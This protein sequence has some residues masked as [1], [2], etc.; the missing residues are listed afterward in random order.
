[1]SSKS[2]F[3]FTL[4]E[5]L[6]VI[7]IIGILIALLLPA[8]Q[9]AREAARRMQCAN[10][11][12]QVGLA[13]HG[14]HAAQLTFPPGSILW[15][16]S[17]D[18]GCR[19]DTATPTTYTGWGWGTFILPY[20]EQQAVYEGID[21]QGSS[22]YTQVNF[23]L[24][25]TR[26]NAFLCPSDPQ[27]GELIRFTGFGTNGSHPNDDCRQTN[28]VGVT[29]SQDWTCDGVW[30]KHLDHADG[31]MA[32]QR[33]CRIADIRDGTS[34]TLVVAEVT[35]AGAG[36]RLGFAWVTLALTD[37]LDGIN[38]PCTVPGGEFDCGLDNIRHTGPASYHPGGCHFTMADGSVQF[39]SESIAS[40]VIEGL[41]TRDVGEVISGDAL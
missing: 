18:A 35:G 19:P 38:G 30:P 14:Y 32:Q 3:G 31:V 37:T 39:L 22:I 9:A 1:M 25:A 10:N 20:L 27:G 11:F 40:T 15:R 2:Q 36:S 21:F 41:T 6:V 8:V 7:T 26:V 5:L 16:S 24:T 33:G 28:I 34:N 4:V 12:K 17:S 13:L 29:D 23:E